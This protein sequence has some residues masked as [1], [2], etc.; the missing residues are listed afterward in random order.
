MISYDYLVGVFIAGVV[1][2]AVGYALTVTDNHPYDTC[3]L[4]YVDPTDQIECV[5]LMRHGTD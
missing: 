2:G 1:I 3:M 5:W 4:E